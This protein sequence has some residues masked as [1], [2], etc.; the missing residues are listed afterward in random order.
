VTWR[1]V[2]IDEARAA[3]AMMLF[4]EKYGKDV[5]MVCVGGSFGAAGADGP[6]VSIELCGGTHVD[7]TGQIGLVA[8]T[9]EEAAASGVRRVEA[10]AGRAALAHVR[11]LGEAVA[12]AGRALG[13]KPDEL[14]DRVEKLQGELKA[15]QR[16][17]AQLRDK[18]AAAQTGGAA[19]TDVHEA[20]G[21]RYATSVLDGLDATALRNAADALLQRSGVDLVA[22][23]SGTMLVVKASE[24]ARERGVHA[25][26]VIGV[27]A[28]A[29]GGRGGGRPDLA[30]AGVRD[31]AGLREALAAVAGALAA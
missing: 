25:G 9:A 7:R 17:A 19:A 16:E 27:L 26:K 14:A 31:E 23:G 29:G 4:G 3:G 18:L 13:A 20:G 8:I 10:V 30:Q 22:V 12:A 5:R 21:V 11:G 24:A 2:P 1:V 28:A 15:A 6:A